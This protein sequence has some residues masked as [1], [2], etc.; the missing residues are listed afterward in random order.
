MRNAE[1]LAAYLAGS[2]AVAR[3]VDGLT[4][5]QLL[6]HPVPS[7]WSIQEVVCHLADTEALFAERMKRVMVEDRPPLLFADPNQYVATLACNQRDV[8]DEVA[9]IGMLRRQM[10]RILRGQPSDVWLRVG[11]HSRDG[12]QT[13]EQLLCKAVNH[14]EHHLEFIRSKRRRLDRAAVASLGID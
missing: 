11:I 6:A 4:A 7:M 12:E 14:L 5:D 3:A 13:L 2:D 8:G 10:S 9:L 1:L